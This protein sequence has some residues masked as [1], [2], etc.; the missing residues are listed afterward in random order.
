MIFGVTPLGSGALGAYVPHS[1]VPATV[2]IRYAVGPHGQK[3][4]TSPERFEAE[5]PVQLP[6]DR[7]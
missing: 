7:L 6:H 4:A 3:V 2:S 5:R 1:F